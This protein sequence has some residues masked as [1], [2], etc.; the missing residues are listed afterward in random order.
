MS[1][2]RGALMYGYFSGLAL[3][4]CLRLLLF[5]SDQSGFEGNGVELANWPS[6]SSMPYESYREV[7]GFE[8]RW[9]DR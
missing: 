1:P 8:H 6:P 5:Q 3:Q 4:I 9:S 2:I 7:A